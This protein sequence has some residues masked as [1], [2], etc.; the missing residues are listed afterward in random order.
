M[1]ISIIAAMA[2]NR[3]IGRDNELPW[4]YPEDLR[5][6]KEKTI[7][8]PVIMGRKTYES[9]GKP[10]PGRWNVVITRQ[11]GLTI[12]GVIVTNTIKDGI[13]CVEERAILEDRPVPGEAFIIGGAQLYAEA[14]PIAE[15]IYLT[16]IPDKVEGDTFFPEIPKEFREKGRE[17][18]GALY[19]VMYE[20]IAK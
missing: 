4:H 13:A 19:F 12:P 18:R 16:L 17:L 6:F 9:I 8:K 5:Y 1:K 15:K 11:K 14:L 20:R 10:L 7:G 3:V 2:P